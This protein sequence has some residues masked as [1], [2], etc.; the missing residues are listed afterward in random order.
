M[1]EPQENTTGSN[2]TY[3]CEIHNGPLSPALPILYSAICFVGLLGNTMTMYVFYLRRHNNTSMAVYMRN[4]ATSDFLL[5]LGLPLR[6]HYHNREGP[7]YLCKVVGLFFY[8]NMYA[9]VLFLCLISLD[10]YLKVVKPVWVLRIH[11]V[12]WSRRASL[13]VWTCMSLGTVVFFLRRDSRTPCE[14]ICFHFHRKS[15]PGG[16]AN[17]AAVTCFGVLFL[18]FVCFYGRIARKLRTMSLGNGDARARQGRKRRLLVKTFAVPLTFT[19]CFLPY[20]LVRV[21]YVLAQ[22]DVI[23]SGSSKQKLHILNEWSLLLSTLNSCLDP[24]IYYLLSCTYRR[25]ILCALQGKSKNMY[26]VNR[27]RISI[28]CSLTEM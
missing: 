5:M 6:I 21:P 10:R 25:T 8:I 9:S 20:H 19:L 13:C 14:K 1:G 12:S 27:K 18:L 7:F 16:V 28:N 15:L 11:R 23:E 3:S 22:M 24:I 4:L 2:S 26:A 17:L